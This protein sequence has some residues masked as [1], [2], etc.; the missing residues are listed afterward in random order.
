M[1]YFNFHLVQ[2]IFISLHTI[3][4]TMGYLELCEFSNDLDFSAIFVLLISS[5]IPLWSKILLC[6]ISIFS[7]F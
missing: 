2:N 4:L 6:M 5:L 3:P 1:L 7:I